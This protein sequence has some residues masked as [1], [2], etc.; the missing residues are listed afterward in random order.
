MKSLYQC[1]AAPRHFLLKG[2]VVLYDVD[3]LCAVRMRGGKHI[4]HVRTNIEIT[5]VT[6][7]RD[8]RTL[9][10]GCNDCS[11]KCYILVDVDIDDVKDV[12]PNIAS[13]QLELMH[14]L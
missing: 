1:D 13:R 4:A 2:C 14:S 12:M 11:F 6:A 10:M 5:C 7:S 3:R 8:D 9:V